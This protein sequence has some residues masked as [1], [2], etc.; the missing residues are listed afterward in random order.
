MPKTRTCFLHVPKSG[1]SSVISAL[2][3][4][5]GPGALFHANESRYQQGPLSPLLARYPIVAGH[6]SFAQI[7]DVL[8]DDTFF[9][10]FLRE[11][12]DRVLSH[13]Y[14]YRS[15]D[16]ARE[17]DERVAAAQDLE[18]EPFVEQL[19]DR[20]S[21]WSNWQTFLFSGATNAEQPAADLLP[22]AIRNL[23]RMDFVGVHDDL[24]EGFQRLCE[25]RGWPVEPQVT[26]VNVTSHRL[27]R[28]QIPAAVLA[29]LQE[30]NDC[31]TTLFARARQIWAE[32]KAGRSTTRPSSASSAAAGASSL[33]RQ[34]QGTREIEITSI[35]T[36]THPPRPD[37]TIHE[38][39]RVFID[40]RAVSGVTVDDLTVGIRI[41]DKL[42]V[43]VYGINTRLLGIS[44]SVRQGE[45][46]E[47]TFD[48]EMRIDNALALHC[49]RG[50]TPSFLGIV[51][52]N[53]Q[54]TVRE[55][56]P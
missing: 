7:S 13:Y 46:F 28:G 20:P 8:L 33:S 5:L 41:T 55:S 12:V 9:S 24:D 29:R 42:G 15:Q 36:R 6:F 54:A 34:E 2:T 50:D 16:A 27:H 39:D 51:N 48:F 4:A 43:E 44:V 23:E 10:T 18:L 26:R 40:L 1:G 17:R 30:L 47:L 11:P 35:A 56:A 37:G 38:N 32:A 52:L 49:Q 22:A 14:Y 31:D 25:L 19:S 45:S 53:A 21:P 3:T